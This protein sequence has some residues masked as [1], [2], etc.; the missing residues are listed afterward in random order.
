MTAIRALLTHY[1]WD[2]QRLIT[3]YYEYEDNP[4]AFFEQA[5]VANPFSMTSVASTNSNDSG[6][7]I[8]CYSNDSPDV[9]ET[10]SF[11]RIYSQFN[12]ENILIL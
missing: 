2:E 8:I 9:N 10:G 5:H 11:F 1:K 7:C 3:E 12:N 6:D 4:A